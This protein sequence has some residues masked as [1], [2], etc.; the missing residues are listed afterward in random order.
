[1]GGTKDF[2]RVEKNRG[3]GT[4]ALGPGKVQEVQV[5]LYKAPETMEWRRRERP[6]KK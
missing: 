3:G 6:G 5:G 4:T 2:R 1:V